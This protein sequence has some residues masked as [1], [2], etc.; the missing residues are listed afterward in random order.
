MCSFPPF[1]EA[2]ARMSEKLTWDSPER[3]DARLRSLGRWLLF[4]LFSAL[5]IGGAQLVSD[6]ERRWRVTGWVFLLIAFPVAVATVDRWAKLLPVLFAYGALR[7]SFISF[8]G[9]SVSNPTPVS[10]LEY[11]VIYLI[12]TACAAFSFS[13][14]NKRNL[15]IVNRVSVMAIVILAVVATAFEALQDRNG[16]HLAGKGCYNDAILLLSG[17]LVFLLFNWIYDRLRRKTA[18]S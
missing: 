10:S 16:G 4:F 11:F 18:R 9:H 3:I 12:L 14:Y 15:S 17:I 8:D 6:G 13:F 5:L 1:A 7:V 2:G